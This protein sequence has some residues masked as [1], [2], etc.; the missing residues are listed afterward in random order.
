M[1]NTVDLWREKLSYLQNQEPIISDPAQKFTLEKQIE[2]VIEKIR[3]K[4]EINPPNL[5]KGEPIASDWPE[6]PPRLFWPV[7]DHTDARAAFERLLTRTAPWRFLPICGPSETGKS[8]ISKQ[9]LKNVLHGTGLA[10][11]RFDFKGGTIGM[12]DEVRA[13]V[14]P[15][16]GVPLPDDGRLNE[17]LGHILDALNKKAQPA[18]LV[19]DTYESAGEA[20]DWIEKQLLPSL[21]RTTWLRVV[22]LGQAYRHALTQSGNRLPLRSLHSN[23]RLRRI[24]LNTVDCTALN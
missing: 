6:E 24:G 7:A 3:E 18:L 16:L 15:G 20:Q 11:G 1:K 19:F 2:E 9:M 4:T 12:D 10:C 17:R 14:S 8:H 5:G 21:I 13:F 22:I 23:F